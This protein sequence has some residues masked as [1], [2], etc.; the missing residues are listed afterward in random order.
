M[1]IQRGPWIHAGNAFQEIP[2]DTSCPLILQEC[3]LGVSPSGFVQFCCH[4]H[5]A[6][7][8]ING[9]LGYF[10]TKVFQL[11]I[12]DEKGTQRDAQVLFGI[13][14]HLQAKGGIH[15]QRERTIPSQPSLLPL[16][17]FSWSCSTW[18][19]LT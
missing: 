10:L 2:S 15:L 19:E 14:S 3:F 9:N 5:G 18:N 13:N 1:W 17:C 8:V 11:E 6:Q 12:L 7:G 16:S 4:S